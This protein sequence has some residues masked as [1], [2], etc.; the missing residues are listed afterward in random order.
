ML[1]FSFLFFLK[2]FAIWDMWVIFWLKVTFFLNANKRQW[3]FLE[4]WD[5]EHEYGFDASSHPVE[6]KW[7][8]TT[9]RLQF[10]H[11]TA[12]LTC[13][14]RHIYQSGP[15]LHRFLLILMFWKASFPK[16]RIYETFLEYIIHLKRFL[17]SRTNM[18]PFKKLLWGQI[19]SFN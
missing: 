3:H 5:N 4:C 15:Q 14:V 16:P 11:A 7:F 19:N 6:P 2:T 8:L 9:K 18:N 13:I 10:W 17:F 1:F 12:E